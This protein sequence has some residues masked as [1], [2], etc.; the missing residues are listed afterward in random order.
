MNEKQEKK[1]RIVFDVDRKEKAKWVKAANEMK[2]KLSVYIRARV[3]G[4]L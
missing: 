1:S 2:L 3:N 4:D